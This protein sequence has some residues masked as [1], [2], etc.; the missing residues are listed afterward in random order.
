MTLNWQLTY[1]PEFNWQ[2]DK[3]LTHYWH[4]PP[5]IQTLY[6]KWPCIGKQK[7]LG[8]GL[9]FCLFVVVF[10]C[11]FL[12]VYL[13]VLFCFLFFL[14]VI[15]I[16]FSFLCHSTSVVLMYSP[17]FDTSRAIPKSATFAIS[18]LP[19]RIFRAAKSRWTHCESKM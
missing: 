7:Y 14:T 17:S 11:F 16:F 2:I 4:L 5:P 9:F 15:V 8:F 13:F 10:F 3:I 6:L 19:T 1:G 12:F 18:F